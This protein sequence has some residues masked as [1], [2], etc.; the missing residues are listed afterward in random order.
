V[1]SYNGPGNADDTP[2]SLVSDDLGNIYVTGKAAIPGFIYDFATVKYNPSGDQV[3]EERFNGASNLND[4]A[5]WVDVDNLGN[6]YVVGNSM[7]NTNYAS[8]FVT[9]KYSQSQAPVVSDISN[10]LVLQGDRFLA[11]R[12][13]D[14]VSDPDTPDSEITW[15]WSGNIILRVVLDPARRRIRVRAPTNWTGNETITFTATDPTGLSDSD[16]ATFTVTSAGIVAGE[17]KTGQVPEVTGLLGN[18]PNPFNPSTTI[19]YALIK[20]T[21]VTLK[22]FSMIGQEVAT[23]VDGVQPA[24]YH[25]VVWNSNVPV[26]VSSGIYVYSL[27]TDGFTQTGRMM[28]TK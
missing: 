8:D 17:M 14:L 4:G 3:W 16:P 7:Y 23:L 18:Y 28:L 24:G 20:E 27:R 9:I 15:S 22:I 5:T 13:D 12:M 10:Q 19:R 6:V 25:S 26:P 11:L 1:A 21:M 2:L